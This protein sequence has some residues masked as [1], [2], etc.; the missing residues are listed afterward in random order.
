LLVGLK[1]ASVQIPLLCPSC[2]AGVVAL[3]DLVGR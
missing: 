3:A 1:I 2:A